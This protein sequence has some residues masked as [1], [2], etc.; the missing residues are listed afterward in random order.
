MTSDPGIRLYFFQALKESRILSHF[1]RQPFPPYS[2]GQGKWDRSHI[3]NWTYFL[4]SNVTVLN[5]TSRLIFRSSTST[6]KVHECS[7]SAGAVIQASGASATC[8]PSSSQVQRSYFIRRP[9]LSL[10]TARRCIG[11]FATRV[12]FCFGCSNDNA[13]GCLGALI[14]TGSDIAVK[15][16]SLT[17]TWT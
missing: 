3:V 16:P 8:L 11:R 6:I 9:A 4:T 7:P 10:I 5:S 13:G 2:F 15:K 17:T 1:R 14:Q 12:W